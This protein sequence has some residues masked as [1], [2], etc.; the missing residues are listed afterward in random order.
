MPF[1]PPVILAYAFLHILS[2]FRIDVQE[3]S[4]R[5]LFFR[6]SNHPESH[7]IFTLFQ[8]YYIMDIA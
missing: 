8:I 7:F 4:E 1:A 5:N 3:K 6:Q 2:Y